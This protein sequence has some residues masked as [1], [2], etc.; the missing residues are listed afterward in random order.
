MHIPAVSNSQKQ[1]SIYVIFEIPRRQVHHF[2]CKA[3]GLYLGIFLTWLRQEV[4]IM[5]VAEIHA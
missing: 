2:I 5:R 1:V 4:A 3:H